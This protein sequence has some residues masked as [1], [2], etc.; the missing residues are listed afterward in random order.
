[1]KNV[2]RFFLLSFT[3]LALQVHCGDDFDVDHQSVHHDDTMRHDDVDRIAHERE[4]QEAHEKAV[5]ASRHSSEAKRSN[6]SLGR[7]HATDSVHVDSTAA[8]AKKSSLSEQKKLRT[9]ARERS[10]QA[11]SSEDAL[12]EDIARNIKDRALFRNR[13]GRGPFSESYKEYTARVRT[14][15]DEYADKVDKEVGLR[16]EQKAELK[17]ALSESLL[18]PRNDND[19]VN[20]MFDM[21]NENRRHGRDAR[22]FDFRSTEKR[23]KDGILKNKDMMDRLNKR[24]DLTDEQKAKFE[25]YAKKER[26]SLSYKARTL[27]DSVR[28][29]AA[30]NPVA[31]MVLLML[32]DTLVMVGATSS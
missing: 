31:M 20:F 2:Y 23:L 13:V 24:L 6:Q 15:I 1:M 30:K 18:S 32:V 12:E 25:Q 3:F 19:E 8:R 26:G 29:V 11:A 22:S 10:E 7:K 9:E 4:A 16:P 21:L 17:R 5:T 27:Y 14:K 28:S